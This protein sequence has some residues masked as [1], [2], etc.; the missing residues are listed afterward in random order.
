MKQYREF[1]EEQVGKKYDSVSFAIHHI[2]AN[3]KDNRI[4]NLVALPK[5]LHARY[6]FYKRLKGM[7]CEYDMIGNSLEDNYAQELGEKIIKDYQ[8]FYKTLHECAKWVDERDRLLAE[9]QGE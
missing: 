1:Y 2:N 9:K 6:H 3:R 5:R 4:E 8:E 7:R